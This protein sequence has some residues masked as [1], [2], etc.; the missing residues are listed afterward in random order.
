M[1]NGSALSSPRSGRH[2]F[3]DVVYDNSS[4]RSSRSNSSR[5]NSSDTGHSEASTSSGRPYDVPHEVQ[6]D[7]HRGTYVAADDHHLVRA[8][9]PGAK[10]AGDELQLKRTQLT[11]P[12]A[13]TGVAITPPV[14]VAQHA[15][16]DSVLLQRHIDELR[17][18]QPAAGQAAAAAAIARM[19][20]STH[21]SHDRTAANAEG[22]RAAA[23]RLG[24]IPRLVALLSSRD[25]EVAGNA[26]WALVRPPAA[27]RSC[28][29]L[30]PP[31]LP[32]AFAAAALVSGWR[33]RCVV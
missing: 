12:H 6:Y 24:A 27:V 16:G 4:R 25:Q 5:R 3:V 2:G 9:A 21:S 23:A 13:T 11:A 8:P 20:A 7:A 22:G 10:P 15:E 28:S 26:A 18:G 29:L 33:R 17:D 19:C 1:V 30:P 32:A 31:P 14:G